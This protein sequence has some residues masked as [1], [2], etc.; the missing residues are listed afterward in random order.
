MDYKDANREMYDRHARE[1][2][3]STAGYLNAHIIKDAEAF[4]ANLNGKDILDVGSGPGRDSA[5]FKEK[6]FEPT[7]LD[8]SEEMVKICMER[9]LCAIVGDLENILFID[10][11]FNGVWAYTSLLHMPKANLLPVLEK[12]RRL[13]VRNGVFYMGM[14]EG[15]FEGW[16]ESKRYP[17]EKRFH[18]LYKD[19]E[20]RGHLGKHFKIMQTSRVELG[21]D[22]YLNY[23]CKKV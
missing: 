3:E 16:T 21:E 1:F 9:G 10:N 13:L 5:F 2:L 12:T 23:L 19:E 22:V 11:S 8:I 14:K 15:D 17:G 18:A 20:L 7:C 4:L 6:G